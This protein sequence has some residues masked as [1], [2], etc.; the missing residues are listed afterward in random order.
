M[1]EN[2][3]T[4]MAGLCTASLLKYMVVLIASTSPPP[5]STDDD[6]DDDD[7]HD[8]D[9]DDMWNDAAVMYWFRYAAMSSMPTSTRYCRTLPL[10]VAAD[11]SL[12]VA[13]C[14]VIN[15]T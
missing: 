4:A 13:P 2:A 15:A 14:D 11:T 1:L 6:D 12:A 9:D 3:L 10:D 7:D 5:P 8:D